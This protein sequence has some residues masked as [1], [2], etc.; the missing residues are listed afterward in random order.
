MKVALLSDIHDNIWNLQKALNAL[1]D[2]TEAVIFCGDYCAPFIPPKLAEL[3][4]PIYS[5]LGNND[6]DQICQLQTGGPLFTWTPLADEFGT[7]KLD[8]KNI[9]FCHYPKLAELL[10]KSGEYDAVFHGHTHFSRN[11]KVGDS[12]LLNPGAICGIQKGVQGVASFAIYDTTT[13]SAE[14]ITI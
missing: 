3:N 12:I 4:V 5:C 6:E 10:A 2:K 9:A 14:I 13:N 1:K 8:H 11:E 7:V